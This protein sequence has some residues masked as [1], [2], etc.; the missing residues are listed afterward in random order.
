MLDH[1]GKH[2]KVTGALNIGPTPQGRPVII[3]AGAS[4][5]GRELAAQTAEVVFGSDETLE[6]AQAF[7]SDLKGRMAKYGR[8]PDG[9]KILPALRV[10]IGESAQEAEDKFQALQAMIHPDVALQYLAG[11]LEA[12]LSGLSL[13][14]PIPEDRIPREA[15]L[16]K[17]FF[18]KIVAKIRKEN[19]TLRQLCM[20]YERGNRTIKGTSKEV[21]DLMEEWFTKGAADGFMLMFPTLPNGLKDFANGV[22][23]ELQRRGLFRT[24]Y[25]GST[26]REHLGLD[27]PTNRYAA[28]GAAA[29][30]AAG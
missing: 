7:Y 9:L 5:A 26:L 23:P 14:E 2:F 22:V 3:E 11:D 24:D 15:N 12:D 27:W 13:D 10:I 1:R 21:A 4:S 6:E 18:D 16:H 29:T 20:S 30:Q 25:T 28:G 19:P 8:R 17:N